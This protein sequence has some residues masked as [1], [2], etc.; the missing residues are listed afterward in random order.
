M[1]YPPPPEENKLS[2]INNMSIFQR[3][4]RESRDSEGGDSARSSS[5]S[6]HQISP[7]ASSAWDAPSLFDLAGY[8]SSGLFDVKP[9]KPQPPA[10]QQPQPEQQFDPNSLCFLQELLKMNIGGQI[11]QVRRRKWRNSKT[12]EQSPG[13][14]EIHGLQAPDNDGRGAILKPK[15]RIIHHFIL[16]I[17]KQSLW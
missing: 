11:N 17:N 9:Q 1:K 5:S 3:E 14:G 2:Y 10:P 8:D 12:G 13:T 16:D 6:H 7:K 4:S 15:I